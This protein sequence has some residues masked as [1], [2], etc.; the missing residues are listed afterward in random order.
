MTEDPDYDAF[1][2]PTRVA[3]PA[4]NCEHGDVRLSEY[5]GED[6]ESP[7][8]L[9][10]DCDSCGFSSVQCQECGDVT[11]FIDGDPRQC[12]GCDA[13]YQHEL[14]RKGLSVSFRR[15]S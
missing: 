12:G 1:D 5:R 2:D 9:A 6:G 14:D 3:C 8:V 10:G 7:V 13:V 11:L 15:V 4:N